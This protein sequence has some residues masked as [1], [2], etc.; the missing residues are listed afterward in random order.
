MYSR[1][2]CMHVFIQETSIHS[3]INLAC[4]ISYYL[5]CCDLPCGFLHAINFRVICAQSHSPVFSLINERWVWRRHATTQN[6]TRRPSSLETVL[7]LCVCVHAQI[8]VY[9]SLSFV[10]VVFKFEHSNIIKVDQSISARAC[11][12]AHTHVRTYVRTYLMPN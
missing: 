3:F 10:V 2:M 7:L 8:I 6:I 11:T 4:Y 1:P 12:R 5:I 9:N